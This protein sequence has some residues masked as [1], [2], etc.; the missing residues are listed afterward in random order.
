MLV[1]RLARKSGPQMALNVVPALNDG[2]IGGTEIAKRN[3]LS[4]SASWCW[5]GGSHRSCEFWRCSHARHYS[6]ESRNMG[7]RGIHAR[8][9]RRKSDHF[10]PSE[11]CY[12][13]D[14]NNRLDLAY[15]EL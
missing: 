14:F 10:F 4:A 6:R 3:Q 12:S 11:D 15:Q 9:N 13:L 8:K 1:G 2:H 7:L 5:A